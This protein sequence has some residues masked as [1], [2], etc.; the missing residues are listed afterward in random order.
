MDGSVRSVPSTIDLM[1]WRSLGS[2][3]GAEVITMEGL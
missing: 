1:T 2:R 3:A